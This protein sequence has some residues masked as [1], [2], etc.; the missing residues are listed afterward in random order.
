MTI[1]MQGF[2][3]AAINDAEETKLQSSFEVK[4]AKSLDHKLEKVP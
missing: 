2:T 4:S 1:T 3:L